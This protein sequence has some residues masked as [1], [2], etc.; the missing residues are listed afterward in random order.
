MKNMCRFL[1][2]SISELSWRMSLTLYNW[3]D[4]VDIRS[5]YN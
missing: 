2:Y 5:N 4:I 3:S 1:D